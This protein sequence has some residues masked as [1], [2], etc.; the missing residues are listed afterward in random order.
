VVMR[1]HTMEDGVESAAAYDNHVL[2]HC[3]ACD[4]CAVIDERSGFLRL[5]CTHCGFVKEMPPDSG[6]TSGRPWLRSRVNF[7]SVY[8]GGESVFGERL[9]LE[10]ICCGGY[11]LWALNRRHLEYIERFVR[12][13]NRER[14]FPSVAGDRQLSDKFPAWL[15]SR[16]HRDEVLRTIERLRSTL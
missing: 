1:V 12:S 14:E 6:K 13:T 2:V 8:N 3:L 16:K 9:W 7:L 11:R 4:A 15:V 10:A 5:T